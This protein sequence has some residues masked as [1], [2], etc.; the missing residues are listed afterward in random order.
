MSGKGTRQGGVQTYRVSEEIKKDER[1]DLEPR[2]GMVV[3]A[4]YFSTQKDISRAGSISDQCYKIYAVREAVPRR[5][6]NS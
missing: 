1:F 2:L 6:N 3:V 4:K 5:V